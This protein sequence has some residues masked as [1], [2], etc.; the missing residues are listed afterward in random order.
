MFSSN[1]KTNRP[2]GQQT[3][4]STTTRDIWD[5]KSAPKHSSVQE[6]AAYA[7]NEKLAYPTSVPAANSYYKCL[8]R[9]CKNVPILAGYVPDAHKQKLQGN[10]WNVI[11]VS[12]MMWATIVGITGW[13]VTGMK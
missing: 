10:A 5:D 6:A 12:S 7:L 2:P 13:C 8:H 3:K 11:V 1:N 9:C 4:K